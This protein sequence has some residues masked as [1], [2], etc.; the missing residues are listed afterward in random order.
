MLNGR[1]VRAGFDQAEDEKMDKYLIIN[2]DDF[3]MCHAANLAV[4]DLFQKGSITSATIMTPCSWAREAGKWAAA[5]PEYA[6]GVHL[7]FTNEWQNYKWGPVGRSDT[8]SLRDDE[9]YMYHGAKE[10][11]EKSDLVEVGS[12][13][14]AQ[15]ERFRSFGLVPS[16]IDNHMGSLYGVKSGRFELLKLAFDLAAE[17]GLP[18]RFPGKYVPGMF[19]NHTLD[20]KISEKFIAEVFDEILMYAK[21][22]RIITPDHL[23]PGEWDGPQNDSYEE[24][25]E[26]IYELYKSFPYGVT[27][28]YIHP[29]L[30]SDELKSITGCWHRR[31]W[32]HRLFSEPQ[33]LS[34]I[35]DC[36]IKLISYRD[37]FMMRNNFFG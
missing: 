5:H 21:R 37:L 7:T 25:K 13:I 22:K 14:R 33:T 1:Y 12:E 15:I 24:Y 19:G 36:G 27:E 35:K 16:H 8:D 29:A 28:T 26:Y 4:F 20:V 3:G 31:V 10:F 34:H 18:F 9:G 6:V 11:E 30:E 17:Y 32:E 23:I 2:A